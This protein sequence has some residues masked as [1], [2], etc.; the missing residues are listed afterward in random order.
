MNTIEI[1]FQKVLEDP[2]GKNW[3]YTFEYVIYFLKKIL[4]KKD[5]KNLKDIM[6]LQ[7]RYQNLSSKN[8]WL[9]YGL[10]RNG[11]HP[12]LTLIPIKTMAWCFNPTREY[13][14]L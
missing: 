12:W 5:F 7:T 10:C 8:P 2:D 13:L 14:G 4:K 1:T 6:L 9:Y 3:E 11:S